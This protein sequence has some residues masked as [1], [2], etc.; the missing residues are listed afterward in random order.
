MFFS[1]EPGSLRKEPLVSQWLS[2]KSE[3]AHCDINTHAHKHEQTSKWP[4]WIEV[5]V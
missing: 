1:V 2:E 5:K 3:E 4:E